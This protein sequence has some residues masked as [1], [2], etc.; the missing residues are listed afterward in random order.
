[1]TMICEDWEGRKNLSVLYCLCDLYMIYLI[2]S[3]SK[4]SELFS[5]MVHVHVST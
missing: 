4:M 3:T 1:M 2:Y 5:D